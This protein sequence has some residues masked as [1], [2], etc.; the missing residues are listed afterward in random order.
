MPVLEA[1]RWVG[2]DVSKAYLDVAILPEDITLRVPND[3]TGWVT[4]CTRVAA[5]SSP[6]IVLEATGTYHVG[7]TLALAAAGMPP[8]V[9]NPE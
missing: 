2:I 5:D 8:A 9:M 7:V 3:D 4:L 6:T 1:R